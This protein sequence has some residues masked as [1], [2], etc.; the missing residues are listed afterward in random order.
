MPEI[1]ER[2]RMALLGA[3]REATGT[4]DELS[5]ADRRL[6]LEL[7]RVNE[8]ADGVWAIA[9]VR[10]TGSE[11][12][13]L[14]GRRRRHEGT[15]LIT[16]HSDIPGAGDTS[17]AKTLEQRI[18]EGV[19]AQRVCDSFVARIAIRKFGNDPKVYTLAGTVRERG[20]TGKWSVARADIPFYYSEVRNG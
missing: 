4:I 14:S 19:V 6:F 13:S 9:S 16:I 12:T 11:P 5:G 20:P 18:A 3:V 15:L 8:P 10:H 1:Q 2:A 7:D 17:V